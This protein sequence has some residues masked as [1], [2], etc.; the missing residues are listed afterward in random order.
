MILACP[1]CGTTYLASE[2]LLAEPGRK[3]RCGKCK[4]EWV[5]E[6]PPNAE[7]D[8][9]EASGGAEAPPSAGASRFVAPFVAMLEAK[10]K[11]FAK[12]LVK[13][14]LR[15]KRKLILKAGAGVLAMVVLAVA[16][17]SGAGLFGRGPDLD[18]EGLVFE[19][20]QP[21]LKFDGGA[22]RL[23]VE[24]SVYNTTKKTKEMPHI[25]VYTLGVDGRELQSWWID[26]P[27]STIRAG[28]R[29]PFRADLLSSMERTIDSVRLEFTFRKESH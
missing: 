28:E 29:K 2:D 24:G 13:R 7:G 19:K 11:A 1:H 27:S 12:A 17:S 20:I 22:T 16:V 4:H 21:E 3:V 23:F 25:R 14:G 18:W 6:S 5:L 8:G 26:P 9:G 15:R 10:R